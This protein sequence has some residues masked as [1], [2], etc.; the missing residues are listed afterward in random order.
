MLKNKK[1]KIFLA[2]FLCF[3][4]SF[5]T[6]ALVSNASS[7][8]TWKGHWSNE[9][10]IGYV[11]NVT[12]N[13]TLK[14]LVNNAALSNWNNNQGTIKFFS[15]N[16]T[17]GR[18]II[19]NNVKLSSVSWTGKAEGASHNWDGS[20]H[21]YGVNIK[22]NEAKPIMNYSSTKLKG[23]IA[24]EFGHALGLKHRT[25]GKNYLLYPYDS[26]TQYTPNSNERST[27]YNHYKHQ[28]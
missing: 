23:L 3:G 11:N 25:S 28:K 8:Y 7:V 18:K 13:S 15:S 6:G 22:L 12:N 2:V 14:S 27:L 21:Y 1:I 5:F 17:S 20:G 16:T 9:T 26:R 24:H 10:S 19:V 4:I